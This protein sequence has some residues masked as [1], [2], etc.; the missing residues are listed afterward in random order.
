MK[1]KVLTCAP[2][3]RVLARPPI[4]RLQ[5]NPLDTPLPSPPGQTRHHSSAYHP[6]PPVM[7]PQDAPG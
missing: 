6:F 2:G 3:R 7:P 4:L 5:T 1:K